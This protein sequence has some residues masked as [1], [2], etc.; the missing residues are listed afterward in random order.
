MTDSTIDNFVIFDIDHSKEIPEKSSFKDGNSQDFENFLKRLVINTKND[1]SSRKVSFEKTSSSKKHIENYLK[2]VNVDENLAA[3]ANKLHESEKK[4]TE[5]I[6]QMGKEVKKGSLIISIVNAA[7]SKYIL[8]SK[9]DFEKYLERGTFKSKLG[10]PEDKAL[11]KSCLIEI[12]DNNLPE[13][14]LLFDTNAS[15]AVFWRSTFLQA[16]FFR[17]DKENT[18][19]AFSQIKD[20]ISYLNEISEI[21]HIDI[22]N[23]VISY[24]RTNESYNHNEMVERVIGSFEPTSNEVDIQKLKQNLLDLS[25]KNKFDGNFKIDKKE[26]K[27]KVKRKYKLD[28]DVELVAHSG[29][30]NIYRAVIEGDNYVIIRTD[31]ASGEFRL[32]D[33]SSEK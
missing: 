5:R 7:N 20:A 15:V 12:N 23:N 21:D 28:N 17:D 31:T 4:G 13:Y 18:I 27:D 8:I 30:H 22:R 33:I 25:K 1:P 24:F 11:L 9:I 26:V 6:K 3:L 2:N 29:T 10:L 32:K 16:I 19:N 14:F